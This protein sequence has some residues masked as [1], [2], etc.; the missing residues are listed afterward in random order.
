MH[1]EYGFSPGFNSLDVLSVRLRDILRTNM[2]Q[3]GIRDFRSK[4]A[5]S[6]LT[7]QRQPGQ[8]LPPVT[9]PEASQDD[10]GTVP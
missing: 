10:M 5:H 7:T 2:V 4:S 9:F 6:S 3:S 8:Y 1:L